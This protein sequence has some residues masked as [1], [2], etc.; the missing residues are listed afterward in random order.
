MQVIEHNHY[1]EL[2]GTTVIEI[3]DNDIRIED[4][5][6]LPITDD[7]GWPARIDQSPDEYIY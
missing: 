1:I 4:C 3:S 5:P 7:M 6:P 2:L